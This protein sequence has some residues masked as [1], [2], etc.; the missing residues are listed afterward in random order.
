MK[1]QMR[2]YYDDK[3]DYLTIF[4]GESRPNYGEEISS[5][6]TVFKEEETDEVIGVGILNFRKKGSKH[7]R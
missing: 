2:I 3:G 4:V 7:R 5:G 6:I 1:G